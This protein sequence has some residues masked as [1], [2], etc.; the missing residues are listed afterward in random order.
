MIITKVIT[1][2]GSFDVLDKNKDEV[3]KDIKECEEINTFYI[4]KKETT[5]S[6]KNKLCKDNITIYLDMKKVVVY[7]FEE[8]LMEEIPEEKPLKSKK[9]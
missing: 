4:V 2:S 7:S 5:A 8:H 9:K 3:L 6:Y 1:S